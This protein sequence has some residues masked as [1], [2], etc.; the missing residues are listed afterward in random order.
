MRALTLRS[1]DGPEAL[2]VTDVTEPDAR[3]R[4]LIE[5][6]AAGVGFADLLLTHG[7]YQARPALPFIPGMEVTGVVRAA[8]E[9]SGFERG[10]RVSAFCGVGG[11]FAELAAAAPA[12]TFP[13]PGSLDF[14]DAAGLVVNYQ[15]AYL[16]LERRARLRRDETVLVQG[17]GGGLGVATVQVARAL[18]GRVL[19]VTSTAAKRA[20]A[21]EAGADEVVAPDEGWPEQVRQWTH[22]RGVDV[23]VD[24]V[25]GDRFDHTLR[26]LAPEGRLVVV[27]FTSGRIPQLTVN[28]LL[29]R[30][31]DVRGAGWREFVTEVD[32][33]FP[34]VAAAALGDMVEQ[35]TITPVASARYPLEQGAHALRDLA[36]RRSTGRAVLTVRPQP[37]P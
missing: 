6:H 16:A 24:P 4:V 34:R 5:V 37:A 2:H 3:D 36:E 21:R 1:F 13:I 20:A 22:G 33:G 29:L 25:G 12:F 18:R 30:N 15:A 8:P 28:R 32:P 23:A 10:T 26:V 7:R 17:A 27:G 11:G 19:A 14:A 35:G 9:G 31:V